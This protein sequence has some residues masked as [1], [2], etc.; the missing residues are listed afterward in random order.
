MTV[1]PIAEKMIETRLR[2]FGHV[3]K[4]HVDVV[5]RRVDHIWSGGKSLEVG[6]DLKNYQERSR[7]Q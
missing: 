2:C 5:V 1:A 6:E 4:R 7:D 3:E